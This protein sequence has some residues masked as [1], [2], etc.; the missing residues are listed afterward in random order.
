MKKVL[1]ILFLSKIV[2]C[3]SLVFP[4]YGHSYGIR[5]ATPAHLFMFFGPRTFFDDPQGLATT[6]LEVWDDSSTEKDD[7][8]VVVYG[9]NSGKHEIIYN[10]SMWS[11]GLYGKKGSKE[12]C[13]LFPKGIAADSKGNVFVADSGNNRVVH[14]FN[15]KSKLQWIAAYTAKSDKDNGFKGPARVA[16]DESGNIYVTD[17]GNRR[18][19]VLAKNGIVKRR[20]PAGNSFAFEDGPTAL[21]VAD[22]SARWSYFKSEKMIFCADRGG[23]RIWKLGI[24]GNM[25]K[26]VKIPD[27]YCASYGA[28]DYYHNLWVT[29]RLKHCVLK[30]DH[31]LNLL[32]IFGSY[33]KEDNQFVEPRGIAIYKRYGQ[34]FIAEKKG[35]QYYW[36]GTELKNAEIEKTDDNGFNLT[37]RATEYSLVSLFSMAGNDTLFITKHRMVFPGQAIVPLRCSSDKLKGKLILKIEPTYSSYSYNAWF[38]PIKLR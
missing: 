10:S 15:P 14:L 27:G 25:I 37:M 36:V 26:K 30:Y 1:I 21:A 18:I 24:D 33:G 12:D 13:F 23:K 5:K 4:P 32:D 16:L 3:E 9:V 6:R 38:F 20:I 22:G 7:D 28:I 31:N 35:A 8:E 19:V 11:L 17:P 34:V 2:I 29:D